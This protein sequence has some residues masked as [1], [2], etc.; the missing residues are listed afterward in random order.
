VPSLNITTSCF[1]LRTP[2]SS[3]SGVLFFE[4]RPRHLLV[5][6]H[7]FPRHYQVLSGILDMK[8][9]SI[10]M[11]E[12]V[13]FLHFGADGFFDFD[14]ACFTFKKRMSEFSACAPVLESPVVYMPDKCVGQSGRL[15][16]DFS[17]LVCKSCLELT[18][19]EFI[20]FLFVNI[21]I[22]H[23]I[24]HFYKGA[25]FASGTTYRKSTCGAG[26]ISR[27]SD[28]SGRP[29][30]APILIGARARMVIL[31][32]FETVSRILD[33]VFVQFFLKSCI[34][35]KTSHQGKRFI[36]ENQLLTNYMRNKQGF[37]DGFYFVIDRNV[38]LSEYFPFIL[39]NSDNWENS[40]IEISCHR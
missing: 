5:C 21:I 32:T 30:R 18:A 37:K 7:P 13:S 35:A 14:P 23:E 39:I 20:L 24:F 8:S 16:S 4:V 2:F 12:V 38:S 40:S 3:G 19:L 27:L 31:L 36:N 10:S 25:S 22:I 29:I 17:F 34:K 33:S 28:F 11:T 6:K 1:A 15:L 26:F 9:I